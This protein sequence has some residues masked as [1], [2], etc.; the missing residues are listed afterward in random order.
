MGDILIVAGPDSS[1]NTTF[2]QVADWDGNNKCFNYYER[3]GSGEHNAGWLTK[4]HL[5]V[6]CMQ[7][8]VTGRLHVMIR[9]GIYIYTFTLDAHDS[10]CVDSFCNLCSPRHKP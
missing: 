1:S 5:T 2:L 6:S 3:K 7:S 9:V 8:D 10:I 4:S